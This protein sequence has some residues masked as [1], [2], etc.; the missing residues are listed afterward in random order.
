[1]YKNH[2]EFHSL[3]NQ[4]ETSKLLK[5]FTGPVDSRLESDLSQHMICIYQFIFDPWC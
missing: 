2:L 5:N 1:M 3:I 4:L